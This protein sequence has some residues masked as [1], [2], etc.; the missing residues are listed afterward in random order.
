MKEI[1]MI[2]AG[3]YEIFAWLIIMLLILIGYKYIREVI[4]YVLLKLYEFFIQH[5]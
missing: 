2:P 5:K 1:K 4:E 3:I